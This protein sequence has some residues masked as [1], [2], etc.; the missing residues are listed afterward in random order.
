MP[1][2][3]AIGT[4]LALQREEGQTH[5]SNLGPDSQTLHLGTQNIK[6]DSSTDKRGRPQWDLQFVSRTVI[7]SDSLLATSWHFDRRKRGDSRRGEVVQGRIDVPTIEPGDS[8]FLVFVRDDRLVKSLVMRVFQLSVGETLP[9]GNE[10]VADQLDLRLVRDRFEIG[11]QDGFI[12]VG[13]FN[14]AMAVDL[15]GGLGGQQC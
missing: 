2:G 14:S 3:K 8:C 1:G 10:T 12:L 4:F 5:V 11:V 6:H 13:W 9:G 15:E 7:V